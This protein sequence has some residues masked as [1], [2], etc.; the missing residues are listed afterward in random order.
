MK[1]KNFVILIRDPA[2]CKK[3]KNCDADV[4]DEIS[5]ENVDHSNLDTIREDLSNSVSN[6][7]DLSNLDSNDSSDTHKSK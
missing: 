7:E 3:R 6:E 4:E 5:F 1:T 2:I